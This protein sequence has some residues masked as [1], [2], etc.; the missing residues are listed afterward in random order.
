MLVVLGR[1][2]PLRPRLLSL[3]LFFL[4][5]GLPFDD[6]LRSTMPGWCWDGFSPGIPQLAAFAGLALRFL[7]AVSFYPV[8]EWSTGQSGSFSHK[9]PE[10]VTSL[11]AAVFG[12]YCVICR[13]APVADLSNYHT[14]LVFFALLDS[15]WRCAFAR[16]RNGLLG[17]PV[18]SFTRS[19]NGMPVDLDEVALLGKPAPSLSSSQYGR[20]GLL[21]ACLL[22]CLPLTMRYAEMILLLICQTAAQCRNGCHG[23][24]VVSPVSGRIHD[25]SE[26]LVFVK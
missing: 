24:K 14:L 17:N 11:L 6:A 26:S 15:C 21:L 20:P 25:G 2:H 18:L 10:W 16:S 5:L 13:N 23:M 3:D 7:G 22:L 12:T 19:R 8:P 9:I 1:L 4:L